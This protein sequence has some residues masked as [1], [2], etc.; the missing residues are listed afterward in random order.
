MGVFVCD[1]V[2]VG[3]FEGATVEDAVVVR[4]A[5]GLGVEV[6]VKVAEGS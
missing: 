4:V 2:G 6:R 1:K 5:V 3:V